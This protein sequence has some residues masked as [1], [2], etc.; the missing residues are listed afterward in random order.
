MA[1]AKETKVEKVEREYV[2]P[3][4]CEWKKVPRYKRAKK[5]IRAIREFLVQHMK[6]RDRD[7]STIRIDKYL[8]EEVWFRG[9]KKPP[10]RIKVKAIKEKDKDGKEIVRVELVDF[11]EK[12]KFKKL[13]EEKVLNEGKEKAKKKKEVEKKPEETAESKEKKEE[14]DE[15]IKAVV[16][17]GEK[18]QK[19]A[20]KKMKHE[21][22]GKTK[23]PKHQVRQA[24][25]K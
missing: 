17:A 19:D 20:A 10:A 4:R 22:G 25:A 16:E 11:S 13:R 2:I 15:K 1:K 24:L 14:T 21:T 3:L 18:M 9:I 12:A 6:I 8:N 7:L 5:A 23:E